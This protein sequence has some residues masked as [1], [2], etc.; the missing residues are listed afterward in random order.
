MATLRQS[1][2]VSYSAKGLSEKEACNLIEGF[3]RVSD[4]MLIKVR[5]SK[6]E[7]L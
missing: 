1:D 4:A 2:S 3:L 7:D 6:R 5:K